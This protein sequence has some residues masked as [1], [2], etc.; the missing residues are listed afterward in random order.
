MRNLLK[1]PVTRQEILLY[2]GAERGSHDPEV[3][4]R[5]GDMSPIY[6]DHLIEIVSAA[7]EM[8]DGFQRRMNQPGM[9][10]VTPFPEATKLI[11][12]LEKIQ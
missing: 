6:I 9:G 8:A 7:F 3:T 11:R 10:F 2:L 5:I 1:H 4:G 12:S